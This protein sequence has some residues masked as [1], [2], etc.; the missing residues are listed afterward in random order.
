MMHSETAA[1]REPRRGQD[2]LEFYRERIMYLLA[3][4]ITIFLTPFVILN[5]RD[6]NYALGIAT[7]AVIATFAI[8]G[9][10][11][12]R[13]L[14][15]PIPFAF[16]LL[17]TVAAIAISLVGDAMHGALWCYPGILLCYFVLPRRFA[18]AASLLLLAGASPMVLQSLGE[19]IA[20]RFAVSLALTI[21][22]IYIITDVIR[23]LQV[24]LL[25]Q[26]ITDPL[27]G[28]Y[29]RRQMEYT[30]D[31]TIERHQRTG[32]PAS[33]VVI[34]IDHFKKINDQFGHD[35][36]D[37]VL[38]ALVLLIKNRSRRLDR[39]FRM[40]G[41]E[42]VLLLPD[43]PGNAAMIQAENLRNR[44]ADAGLLKNRPVTVSMG[45]AECHA[46]MTQE[47]WIKAADTALYAAKDGGRN[48]VIRAPDVVPTPEIPGL[49]RRARQS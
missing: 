46:E 49:E 31:E 27:T 7:A 18:I 15:P 47:N 30:L 11:I 41:E 17:P 43:T 8:D 26:A 19:E 20:V 10:A 24:E 35:A 28:A 32:A 13:K 45:V 25:G 2:I 44:I 37:R 23:E 9:I 14:P 16:L 4:A 21:V 6:G 42:F 40:G 22:V 1:A 38:K 12:H 29:N 34:D 33:L 39:L 48:R 3:M 5:F 36:G